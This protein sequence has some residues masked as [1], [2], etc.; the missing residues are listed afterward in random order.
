MAALIREHRP[1]EIYNLASRSS[2][3]R[4]WA[5]PVRVVAVN[6]MAAAVLLGIVAAIRG[7]QPRIVQ[8]GSAEMF[9][10][11][12]DRPQSERGSFHPTN[13]Y[14]F[15]KV[16]AHMAAVMFRRSHG[17]FVSNAILF[18]HESPLRPAEFVSRT[19]TQAAAAIAAGR[20]THMVLGD[21][22]V[23]RD[24]GWAPDYMRAVH[25][26]A[27]AAEPDDFV[28]ATGEAHTVEQFA[29]IALD[30]AG[31]HAPLRSDPAR[32]RPVDIPVMWGD[33][34]KARDVLDWRPTV[35]FSQVV[36]RMVN[37]DMDRLALGIEE[38]PEFA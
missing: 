10:P 5:D 1:D 9:G 6:G 19:I 23:R 21:L 22:T 30:A 31:V 2:V 16:F 29:R 35:G 14:A 4:S 11:P 25:L 17:L 32:L 7:Y 27:R 37:V 24:W 15:S 28:L 20:Q 38:M 34:A 18:N 13:P 33:P 12:M 3:A 26:M 36:Q 8:A